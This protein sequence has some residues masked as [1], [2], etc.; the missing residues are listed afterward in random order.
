M[1]NDDLFPVDDVAPA[2]FGVENEPEEP[3]PISHPEMM[4]VPSEP[5]QPPQDEATVQLAR[6]EDKE[7]VLLAFSSPERLSACLGE[8]QAWL[9][10]PKEQLDTIRQRCEAAYLELDPVRPQTD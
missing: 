7:L 1:S 9:G 10:V 5:A 4:F 3:E 6:A 8:E 2:V